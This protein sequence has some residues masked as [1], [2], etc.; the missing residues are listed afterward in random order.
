MR[1]L[2]KMA[3]YNL[4][5]RKLR[6]FLTLLGVVIGVAA[7][8]ATLSLGIGMQENI[9]SQFRK[10][11][12]DVVSVI[13]ERVMFRPG[14]PSS[15]GRV[16]QLT[17]KDL[18]E[19]ENLDSV[20]RVAGIIRSD[21]KIEYRD[22]VGSL[23]VT[24]VDDPAGWQEINPGT[25]ELERGRW[26][27]SDERDSIVIGHSVAYEIFSED[28]DLKKTLTI[29]NADFRVV[30]IL[31]E[32]GGFA[33][34]VDQGIYMPMESSR[35][36]FP[37]FEEDEFS[38]IAAKVRKGED[39]EE[40]GKEIEERMLKLHKQTEETKTFTVFT[41]KFFQEQ[42]NSILSSFTFF[43]VLLGLISLLIGGI[44]I[45]NIM[46]VSVMERTR[47][48]GVMKAT[49]ATRKAILMLFLIES[50]AFGLVGGILGL[51]L[52][53]VMSFGFSFVLTGL[54]GV[55]QFFIPYMSLSIILLGLAFGFFVGV[56]SGYFPARRA[57]NLQPVEALR[58][59]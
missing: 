14:T 29:N 12:G 22:D 4:K 56:A 34:A 18:S 9:I 30:G 16:I 49:G 46:Y 21:A 40:V 3:L 32:Q 58:Y 31:K 2:L 48:I 38:Q 45:M 55:S 10:F 26:F 39:V 6:S 41:P 42:I 15:A 24:G 43:L 1:D 8:V 33:I 57:S 25:S 28:I 44:G 5:Q 51:L 36:I 13:P 19:I 11:Q 52:G 54:G 23:A 20:E 35:K 59:E 17:E 53:T 50:G 27:T 37:Q 7:V 47:E